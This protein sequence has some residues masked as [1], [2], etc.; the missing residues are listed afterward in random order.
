MSRGYDWRIAF[1]RQG[2]INEMVYG[3]LS[4]MAEGSTLRPNFWRTRTHRERPRSTPAGP[5]RRMAQPAR[6][7]LKGFDTKVENGAAVITAN[8]E[9]P[10]VKASMVITWPLING[11]A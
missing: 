1:D 3:Q 4:L 5:L 9:V 7:N 8:Y 11:E 2:F 10:D 6:M